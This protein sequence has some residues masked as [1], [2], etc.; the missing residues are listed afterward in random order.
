MGD[1]RHMQPKISILLPHFQTRDLTLACLQLLRQRTRRKSYEVIVIDNGSS[2][3]SGAELARL[4]WVRVLRRE[5]PVGERPA[6]SHGMALNLGVADAR[7][8]L[9]LTMH[10]DTMVLRGDWLD[11]LLATLDSGGSNCAMVGSWK[12]E[13][14]RPLRGLFKQL[15]DRLRACLGRGHK[16]ERYIRS[17]CA[18]Y[19]RDVVTQVPGMFAPSDLTR[20]PGEDLYWAILAAGHGCRFIEP[21][22]LGRYIRH[23]NH[24]TMALNVHLGNWDPY[25]ARTRSRAIR[26]INDFLR[27]HGSPRWTEMVAEGPAG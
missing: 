6:Y 19:R 13:S 23:L 25:M 9:L 14:S 2:D 24:A 15:E 8:P 17:H 5:V 16:G 4:P 11:F 1:P 12:L 22:V 7:A 21:E 26:R 3:G 10:T 20:G 18:L 27:I